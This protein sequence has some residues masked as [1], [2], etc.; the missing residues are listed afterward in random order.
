MQRVVVE[1]AQIAG[2]VLRLNPE[3]QHYLRR[4]LR[5]QSG[6]RFLALDGQGHLWLATLMPV[7]GQA[8]LSSASEFSEAA[9]SE[10]ATGE[11][12]SGEEDVLLTPQITLAACLP[13]QGFDD[14]VRQVT[15]LGV[16]EIVPIVSD[17]TLLRPSQNKLD[18]WRRIAAEATEQSERLTV[19]QIRDPISW[20]DWL[21]T[22]FA[23]HRYICVARQSAPPLLSICLSRSVQSV[24]L[25]IGPEGGWTTAEVEAATSHQYQPVKLG[26][27][28]L[29]AVTAS[30]AALSIL[31]AGLEFASIKP[32]R[33]DPL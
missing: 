26:K 22:S 9:I 13:K 24:V 3:Q 6:D 16:D 31:Q 18:R 11:S 19:S 8:F 28:V 2:E 14:V 1:A 25:A 12:A 7:E 27:T 10:L 29:R 33:A 21:T 30:V 4:V 15:E 5:L 20:S 17:R 23:G 32:H